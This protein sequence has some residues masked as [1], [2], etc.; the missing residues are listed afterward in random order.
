MKKT[1]WVL[2]V[3]L[4]LSQAPALA[5]FIDLDRVSGSNGLSMFIDDD[6]LDLDL[7]REDTIRV[8]LNASGLYESSHRFDSIQFRVYE[9][10]NGQRLFEAKQNESLTRRQGNRNNIFYLTPGDFSS[11]SKDIEIEVVDSL[12]NI[13]ATFGTEL[14]ASNIP[15]RAAYAGTASY[16]CV[17]TDADDCLVEKLF[18]RLSVEAAP[19][20][21]WTT[22][23][24]R[25]NDG[26]YNLVVPSSR[27]RIN[28]VENVTTQAA[29]VDIDEV[30]DELETRKL[31]SLRFN[32]T[33]LS[34]NLKNGL[35]EFDGSDLY[36]TA[37]GNRQA[38]ALGNQ[39]TTNNGNSATV[40]LDEL[41]DQLADRNVDSI[42]FNTRVLGSVGNDGIMEY[43][44]SDLYF[45]TNGS[46]Q[47]IALGTLTNGSLVGP[48]G[49][50]GPQG[51]RGVDGG[52]G[53][54]GNTGATGARGP[55][56]QGVN[57]DIGNFLSND[58]ANGAIAIGWGNSNSDLLTNN[59]ANSLV[60]GFSSNAATVFVGPAASNG[61]YGNVG[62]GTTSPG[63]ILDVN[64][65][66]TTTAF[67]LST[68]PTNGYV[69]TSDGNGVASWAEKISADS[70]NFT[71]LSDSLSLDATTTL[72]LAGADLNINGSLLMLDS[73][74]NGVGLGTASPARTLHITDVMRLE[75]RATAPA[76]PASGDI[77]VDSTGNQAFCIYLN[78]SWLTA[79][80]SGSCS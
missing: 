59:T 4:G 63:S 11:G 48:Q 21:R 6:D 45:T 38:I 7:N 35:L 40:D 50:A 3:L 77:Y 18:D 43:D 14:T 19:E 15:T 78:G 56:G 36:F 20:R 53:A 27:A 34:T 39:S 76:S 33:S 1:L 65:T 5:G 49:P 10:D 24:S 51:P 44:G 79:A 26:T 16:N 80:G 62:I 57:G 73:S 2:V 46:R 47:T 37:A 70:L 69:L 64:G 32:A 17:S 68:S 67:T 28:V 23:M 13:E 9:V 29:D 66:L 58:F 31:A 12:G 52:T 41:A 74:A 72:D 71:H 22:R 60:I 42:K 30:V 55:S 61:G 75:P 8:K 54:T 25:R